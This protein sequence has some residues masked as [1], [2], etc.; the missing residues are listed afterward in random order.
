MPKRNLAWIFVILIIVLLMWQ[1]PQIIAGRDSVYKAFGPLV[2]VRSQIQHRYVNDVDDEELVDAAVNA[3]INAMVEYLDDPHAIYLDRRAYAR[4][5]ERTEGVFGG[6]GADVW[7]TNQGLEVLSREPHSPAAEASIQPGDIITH[8]DGEP[9]RSVPLVEAVN[10]MLNGTPGTEV[11]L[12]LITPGAEE[13]TEPR[14]Q[15]SP[16]SPRDVTVRRAVIHLDPVRGWSREP[17]GDWLYILDPEFRIAYIRLTK[18]TQNVDEQLDKQVGRLVERRV[19]GLVL[20]LR[21]NTGGLLNSAIEV[22]DRFLDSGLIVSTRGRKTDPKQ[23]FATHDMAYPHLPMAVLIN[24]STASAAE[25]V[26][27]ALRDHGRAAIIGERS[28]GKG[29]VQE[30]VELNRQQ[31]AIKL[32]TAYY[33][34]PNGECIHKT[35]QAAL[36]TSWGVAPTIPVNLSESQEIRWLKMWRRIGRLVPD[37]SET[38]PQATRP[39]D[40]SAFTPTSSGS[41]SAANSGFDTSSGSGLVSPEARAVAEELLQADVQLQKA[42][43]YLR[44]QISPS[45]RGPAT[46]QSA[47]GE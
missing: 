19:R 39:D 30:V 4:F 15:R 38:K 34:L 32:T 5:K 8:I 21:E 3:G 40:S 7:A 6:I 33:Y 41:D 27:G 35:P 24:G 26:A 46:T 29:C 13:S 14:E 20:D 23:W 37:E 36:D 12:T 45:A 43:E 47:L 1:M 42:V 28:Y 17:N 11:T 9:V 25:I 18:F 16:A 2:D 10:N 44:D 22:A 31:G